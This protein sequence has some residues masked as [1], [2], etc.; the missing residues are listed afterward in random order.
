MLAAAEEHIPA[1]AECIKSEN[2][3]SSRANA[4]RD[5]KLA[6]GKLSKQF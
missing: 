1:K 2:V 5:T 3:S 4:G 6:K